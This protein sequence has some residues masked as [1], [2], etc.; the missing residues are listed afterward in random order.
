MTTCAEVHE[1]LGAIAD[2]DTEVTADDRLTGHLAACTGCA[3]LVEALHMVCAAGADVAAIT[4][5]D[6]LHHEIAS[7]PCRRW[8]GLLFQAVDRE[9]SEPNLARLLTHLDECPS[10]RRTWNDLSLIHQVGEAMQPPPDLV[11]R[12]IA[13]RSRWTAPRVLGRRTV[14]AAAY[15][16]AVLG[17]LLIGNPVSLARQEQAAAAV[18]RIAATVSSEVT[19][20]AEDGRGELRVML[21][22]TL[23]WSQR[24][25]DT[26]A[27]LAH[28]LTDDNRQDKETPD[29]RHDQQ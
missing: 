9:I 28:L 13:V 22:R 15:I 29:E 14:A 25:A 2:G 10:C 17:S 5:P 7:S 4:P 3:E 24:Q 23:R 20:V 8:L 27:N 12:C 11:G 19:E 26:V 21:W 6:H 16:L 18:Q 1:L